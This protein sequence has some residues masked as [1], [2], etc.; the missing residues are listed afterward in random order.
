ML[1]GQRALPE[2]TIFIDDG[3]QNVKTA[4]AMGMK[5][6]CPVNNEYWT[7]ALENILH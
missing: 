1:R 5:T 2:E 4:S 3:P 7:E 6:L